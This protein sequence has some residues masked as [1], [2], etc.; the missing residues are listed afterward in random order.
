M[1]NTKFCP[2]VRARCIESLCIA[3]DDGECVLVKA[4]KKYAGSNESYCSHCPDVKAEVKSI[5]PPIEKILDALAHENSKKKVTQKKKAVRLA[6]TTV[7]GLKLND[8]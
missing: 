3:F 4:L 8:K 6:N 2:N 5:S 7:R 1:E